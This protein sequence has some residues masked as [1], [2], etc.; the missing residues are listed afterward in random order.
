MFGEAVI[1]GT[2]FTVE[3]ILRCLPRAKAKLRSLRIILRSRLMTFAR[4][5]LT[6][7]MEA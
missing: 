7:W 3:H 2:R 6:R 1:A 5:K 4:R